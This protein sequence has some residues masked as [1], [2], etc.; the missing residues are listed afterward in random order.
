MPPAVNTNTL[1]YILREY[2]WRRMQ[3]GEFT[4]VIQNT[5]FEFSAS[6]YQV[7]KAVH[8]F[9]ENGHALRWPG[10]KFSARI[11]DVYTIAITIKQVQI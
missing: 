2:L 8:R 5:Q 6:A 9:N 10:F 1:P 7:S 11:I 3:D 4:F